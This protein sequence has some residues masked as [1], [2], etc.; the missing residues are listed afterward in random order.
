MWLNHFSTLLAAAQR[1]VVAKWESRH[2]DEQAKVDMRDR[3]RTDTTQ[4]R[5]Q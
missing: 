3:V 1:D 4:V 2:S 5:P